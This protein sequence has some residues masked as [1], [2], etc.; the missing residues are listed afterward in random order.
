[1]FLIDNIFKVLPLH[2][3]VHLL[4]RQVG[5][6]EERAL[7]QCGRYRTADSTLPTSL[8]RLRFNRMGEV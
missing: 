4:T 3:A 5:S 2:T 6:L 8:S 7:L 1:M